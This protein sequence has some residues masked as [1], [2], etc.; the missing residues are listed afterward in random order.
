MILIVSL[1]LIA[2]T[3]IGKV[4]K[5]K[6][7]IHSIPSEMAIVLVHTDLMSSSMNSFRRRLETILL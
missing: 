4:Q 3:F 5:M 6:F 1:P 7:L 2:S